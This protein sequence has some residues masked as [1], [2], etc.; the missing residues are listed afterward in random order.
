MN[1]KPI[2]T[3]PKTAGAEFIAATFSRYDGMTAMCERSPFVSFW[4]PRTGRFYQ[5][6]SHWLCELPD[7][8]PPVGY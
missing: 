7:S 2:D 3:A 5:N 6:P 1:W 4:M 8:F